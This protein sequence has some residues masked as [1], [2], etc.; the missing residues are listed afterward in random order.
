MVERAEEWRWSSLWRRA[1]GCD[2]LLPLAEWPIER[3]AA[4]LDL[5]N[6]PQT[7]DE[8]AALRRSLVRGRPYGSDEWASRTAALLALSHTLRDPGRPRKRRGGQD[9]KFDDDGKS[10]PDQLPLPLTQRIVS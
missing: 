5:V 4:W 6:A 10:G 2:D 7:E 9:G 8:L 1:N 3:P